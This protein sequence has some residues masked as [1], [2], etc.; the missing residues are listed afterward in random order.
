MSLLKNRD[1]KVF[2]VVVIGWVCILLTGNGSLAVDGDRGQ[3]FRPTKPVD[4]HGNHPSS[5]REDESSQATSPTYSSAVVSHSPVFSDSGQSS[6]GSGDESLTG[7]SIDSEGRP[8][9]GGATSFNPAPNAPIKK[10][11]IMFVFRSNPHVE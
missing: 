9:T 10:S 7:L 3:N 6:Y 2:I 1:R 4:T 5:I 8:F 11:S